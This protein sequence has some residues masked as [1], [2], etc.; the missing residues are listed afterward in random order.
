MIRPIHRVCACRHS[1]LRLGLAVLTALALLVIPCAPFLPGAAWSF[2]QSQNPDESRMGQPQQ[3]KPEASLPNL[4][5]VRTE[6][7]MTHELPLPI[8]STMRLK[9]NPLR[10]WDGR[11]V[12]DP[13]PLERAGNNQSDSQIQEKS[14]RAGVPSTSIQ[15]GSRTARRAHAPRRTKVSLPPTL[16]DDDFLNNFYGWALPGYSPLSTELPYW[17]DQLRVGYA[18]G[19][20]SLLLAAIELGK[21][22]FESAAYAGRGRDNHQYVYDLYKTYLMREPDQGGW[23]FWTSVVSSSGREN[24]RRAF[25]ECGEFATLVA[26]IIPNGATSSNPVSLSTSRVDAHNQPGN[27][28]LA[29]DAT[30][31]VPLLSL[32]GRA[33]LDLGLSLSYS[34]QV[35]TRSGPYL[36]FDEDNGFPSPGFRLGFPTVQRK[37]F[38]AQ[39][40]TNTYLLITPSGRRVE[41]RQVGTSNIYEAGDSSYLQLTDNGTSWLVRSTDGTQLSFSE[42]NGEYRCTQVKDRNGNYLTVNYDGMGHITTA[43]DTLG[44]VITFNYDANANLLSITQSWNG[45]THQWATFGWGT[46]TMQSSFTNVAVVGTTNGT[47][48]PVL[49]Q[50]AVSD[51]SYFQFDYT[52]SLQVLAITRK[53]FDNIQRAQTSFTYESAVSD[54]LR[55][56]DSSISASNWT[57]INGVPAQ[58]STHYEVAV[59]GACVMTAADG[60]IYKEYYGSG[61]QKGLTTL[62]E[63]W[64]GGVRQKWTTTAWTQDNPAVSYETNPRVTENNVYDAGGNRRRTTIDYTSFSLP[65]AVREWTGAA[66]D[67]LYR[68]TTTGYRLDTEYL[69]RRIIGLVDNVQVTDGSG[70]LVS[71]VTYG[72]DWDWSEDM[73][74]DTPA[75]ATQHDRT[76]YGPTLIYGRGNLSQMGRWDVT[77]PQNQ[78]KVIETKWRV[79]STGSVLMERDHLWHQKLVAYGDAFSDS[80]NRNTFAY[81]TTL[82]DEDGNNSLVQYNFDF[83]ATTRTQGPPPAGQS[84]GAIQTMTYNAVGQLER[85][86]TVNN[87]AYRRFWYGP[88]YT[89]SYATVNNIA[90]EAYSIQTL[91][92][93]GRTIGSASNFPGSSGG[94][95]AQLTI[96]DQMGRVLKTSNP[97]EI[98]SSWSPAGDDAAGWLYTQQ[99]YDWKGRPLVTTNPDGTT[100]EASYAGCGCAG[101]EVVTLT[102]EG[103]IDGGV[104]KRRQQ[105]IYSDV[106]GR[107]SKT[108]VLNWQGGTVYSA[109]VNTYNERDQITQVRQYAGAEGSGTYQD[110]AMT[111]DGYGRLKTRHLPE[112]QV[113]PNNPNSTDHTTWTYN[114]DGTIATVKDARGALTTLG[115]SGSNRGLVMSVTHTM[116]GLPTLFSSFTYDPVGNRTSMTDEMGS[117]TYVRNQ[118]S[119]LTS[120]SRVITGVGTFS[121]TYGG[122]NLAG[123]PTSITDP[124]GAVV[125]YSY[126]IA[127][128]ASSVTGANFA[129]ISSY[130]SNFQYRAWGA[131]KALSYGNARTL[132]IGYDAKLQVATYEIPGV[133]KKGY[134]YYD[135]GRLKFT[136]DQLVTNSK[137]D[138]LYKYDH[139]GDITTALSGAEA[140]GQ[141]TTDDR[142]YNETMSY[143][144]FGHLS[145]RE[146]RNWNRYDTTGTETYVNNR[147]QFWHYDADGRLTSG[148]GYYYYDAAGN[149][150]SFGDW[151]SY[152]TD[153][154]FDGDGRRLK[155]L[156]RSYDVNTN[157]WTTEDVTYYITS[158]VLG[159]L[160]SEVT[161]TGAKKRTFVHGGDG[162]LAIQTVDGGIQNVSWEHYDASNASFWETNSTGSPSHAAEIDPFGAD[163]EIV[164]PFTWP[165]RESTGQ[166]QPY[167]TVALLNSATQGCVLDGMP[168]PCEMLSNDNSMQC[169][170]NRC[171]PQT[172]KQRKG[173]TG[174]MEYV[175]SR[176]FQATAEGKGFYLGPGER[177]EG[178][179]HISTDGGEGPER[180]IE[181]NHASSLPQNSFDSGPQ[182]WH[183]FRW[184][185]CPPVQFKITG[186]GPNQAPGT[187]A[188]SQA[189]RADIPD[190][191]VAIKPGNFGVKGVNG[192][193]RSV[194]LNMKFEVDWGKATPAGAPSGI[195]TEGPFSPVDNIGPAS[196]RNSA[197]NQIDVYNYQKYDDALASTRTAMV[198]T[199]IPENTA[200]VKCPE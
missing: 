20:T 77:D 144:V 64:S 192:N 45:Q 86:T 44:R 175:L 191:G 163:A 70:A 30:W 23:D 122:Y 187:T 185:K 195:P 149:A 106:L 178:N 152:M 27:G 172:L 81:P 150:Y 135:D 145:L 120:E 91:D 190:G 186:I 84:Q 107:T 166:L 146:L 167:Y 1:S 171:G 197:G 142:P 55:V 33:G 56:T 162:A 38:D 133:Q 126:D 170:D 97:A 127:G 99:T 65:N 87:G 37:T 117:M 68:L 67:V 199:W 14:E 24:V 75:A 182:G 174:K 189:A 123:S 114:A 49:T 73:F 13:G 116:S 74:Q 154:T 90:D 131:I 140:R 89:T 83:G 151:D 16:L 5:T 181:S 71:K 138:R 188:I 39:T 102:D 139:V 183:S 200:G 132:S 72:Y 35:W 168:T 119:Q 85:V 104:A 124:F 94:Y 100:R 21:T 115:Y 17:R 10:P 57:G 148:N 96:Y 194:F 134:Q 176:P 141:G 110:T 51:G 103:T 108:E 78:S 169:R 22:L 31:N 143:D 63:V 29:R 118:L 112:Q 196:V 18:H 2:A 155:T 147:R 43:T 101:G 179:G 136:Q 12:G 32:P 4:A 53:S 69:N 34:S 41:L 95:K 25:E 177:Y 42:A 3:G 6:T 28:M 159:A 40:G 88:D 48:L 92:G 198:T 98:N 9:K 121:L 60:T 80:V 128:R 11:R 184:I 164:K 52:N 61:W 93:F 36:Y 111:Y 193:N 129:G 7:P 109:T 19:Q 173:T 62:S 180:L 8:P 130:A 47:S 113:D 153:Q 157:Q 125:N 156:L 158:S 26:T 66:A 82:T 54:V 50:V 79:S 15:S 58:V 137:F 105:K 165:P 76:N 160:V 46:K 161:A 59:D